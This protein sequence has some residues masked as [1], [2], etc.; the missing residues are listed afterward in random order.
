MKLGIFTDPHYSSKELSC[1]KRFNNQ[2]LRKIEEAM[3]AFSAA[4]CD[5]VLCLGD[6]IDTEATHE[7]EIANLRAVAGILDRYSMECFCLMGNHDGFRFDREEFYAVLGEHHRPRDLETDGVSLL[8]VDACY[9]R[10][11]THYAPG[12]SDWKD[13]CYPHTAELQERLRAAEGKVYL[14]FH[15][16]LDPRVEERHI[17]A[18]AAEIRAMLEGCGKV[19]AVYQGHYHPGKQSEQNGIS[20]ITFPAMCEM[21]EGW[22]IF[23]I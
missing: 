23:D 4:N 18:N 6:V 5:L 19:N 7:K 10:D 22:F 8:F 21:E 15:Q 17:L 14:F 3:D 20:Y 12:R 11:G 16:N 1:E 9:H 13:V 2:S